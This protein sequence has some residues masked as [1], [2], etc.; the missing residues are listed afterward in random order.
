MKANFKKHMLLIS[1]R[2]TTLTSTTLIR[3]IKCFNRD[4]LLF[5]CDMRIHCGE[6]NNNII[7][8]IFA[9]LHYVNLEHVDIPFLLYFSCYLIDK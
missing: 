5:E 6:L 7:Y 8:V 4:K 2:N 3:N 9:K 1:T